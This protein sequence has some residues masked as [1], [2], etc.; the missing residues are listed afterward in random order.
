MCIRQV[1]LSVSPHLCPYS[2]TQWVN[3]NDNNNN[4]LLPHAHQHPEFLS[5][6]F[7]SCGYGIL[8]DLCLPDVMAKV[9][10]LP[11]V[12]G[13]LILDTSHLD[14]LPPPALPPPPSYPLINRPRIHHHQAIDISLPGHRC[15]QPPRSTLWF[16][17]QYPQ[18][19]IISTQVPLTKPRIS[20][21]Q[22]PNPPS[23]GPRSPITRPHPIS[24]I[25]SPP[26][27]APDLPS[28]VP[29]SPI[30]RPQ[31]PHH[32]APGPPSP[33]P[34]SPITRLCSPLPIASING[35]GTEI[36][37]ILLQLPSCLPKLQLN[38]N[39]LASMS[40]VSDWKVVFQCWS[41]LSLSLLWYTCMI[42]FFSSL[43]LYS[44]NLKYSC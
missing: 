32:Q 20:H 5:C 35:T 11:R 4:V 36:H 28:S 34:R 23:S 9:D 43:L 7:L 38:D 44:M 22:Y 18:S 14:V 42:M 3:N 29:Q 8:W 30:T 12:S 13:V 19:P 15:H 24:P 16:P 31:V 26:H 40:F 27:Q 25:I 39:K 21:H 37:L 6:L 1:N 2:T 17:H 33:G 10:E 41:Q